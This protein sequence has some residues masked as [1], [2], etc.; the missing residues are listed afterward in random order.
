MGPPKPAHAAT[1]SLS[2]DGLP[3]LIEYMSRTT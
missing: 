2:G 1:P 3:H